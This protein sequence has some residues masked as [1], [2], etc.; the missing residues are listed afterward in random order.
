MPGQFGPMSRVRS[1]WI[2][3]LFTRT[4]SWAGIP[5][6][7][8]K[9]Q[10]HTPLCYVCTQRSLLTLGVK[11]VY[12][13]SFCDT[14]GKANFCFDRIQ[15]RV[16][17]ESWWDVNDC[18]IGAGFEHCFFDGVKNG[19]SQVGLT[20]FAW[21]YSSDQIRSILDCCLGVVCS[22]LTSKSLNNQL[23]NKFVNQIEIRL[24]KV[25]LSHF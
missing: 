16:G 6:N 14:N 15:N 9:Q 22:L 13:R 23:N 12:P 18:R 2:R 11:C 3:A 4:I 1:C 20:P 5:F 17:C 25:I 21:G 10:I 7:G 24:F 19:N 8:G